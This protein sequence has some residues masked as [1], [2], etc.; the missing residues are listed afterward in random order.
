[1]ETSR[2]AL[3]T[4]NL[5]RMKSYEDEMLIPTRYETQLELPRG[6]YDLRTVLSDGTDFGVAQVPLSVNSYDE[7]QLALSEIAICG[8]VRQ[9][10]RELK[11]DTAKPR[12]NYV[13]LV[14][15]GFE[16]THPRRTHA[17]KGARL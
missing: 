17:S 7:K 1:M 6:E 10:S 16:I 12:E 5:T 11:K 2:R 8:R 14:S 15:N 3:V 9:V 4:G 13:A